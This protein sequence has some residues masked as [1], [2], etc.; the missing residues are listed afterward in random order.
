MKINF[1]KFTD[2]QFLKTQAALFATL[3]ADKAFIKHLQTL[4]IDAALIE[5]NKEP[6]IVYYESYKSVAACKKAGKCINDDGYHAINLER[7]GEHIFINYE[8]CPLLAAHE[9]LYARFA[10]NDFPERYAHVTLDDIVSRD[11]QETYLMALAKLLDNKENT[12]YVYGPHGRGKLIIALATINRLLDRHPDKTAGVIDFRAFVQEHSVDYYENKIAAAQAMERLLHLDV[13]IVR[14]FG[15]EES[16]KLTRDVFSYPLVSERI[17]AGKKTIFIS[18]VSISDLQGLYDPT[19]R[20]V[21]IKHL[22]DLLREN[23]QEAEVRGA[24]IPIF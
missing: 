3:Q 18:D 15:N 24:N 8:L 22:V 12:V 23:A 4:N 21:R 13:L 17:K 6:L 7:N 9:L 10:Y 5:K 19:R 2:E 1:A 16:N 20:D 11:G 14:N